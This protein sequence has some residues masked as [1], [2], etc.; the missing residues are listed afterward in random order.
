MSMLTDL[1]ATFE[2][3]ILCVLAFGMTYQNYS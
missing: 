1:Q 3:K 2:V